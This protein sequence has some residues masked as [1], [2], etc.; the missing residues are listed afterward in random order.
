[1]EQKEPLLSGTRWEKEFEEP[2][3]AHWKDSGMFAFR[4]GRKPVFSIDTPPPYVNAPVHIGHAVTYTIMDMIA[5]YK[6]MRGFEV[7]FP[8][9]LDRNGLPIEVAAEKKF[10]VSMSA[11]PRE[12]FL[13]LCE[14][15]LE[16][17]S[18]ESIDVFYKLGHSY[19]SWIRDDKAGGMYYTDS[20]SYRALTQS[21]FI[22]LWNKG[23]IYPDEKVNNYCPHCRT[24][25]ADSE[26]DYRE[27]PTDFYHIK[28]RVKETAETVIIAT[29]RPELLMTCAMI[30][31]N[32]NDAKYAH[33]NGRT[34]VI[35]LFH[36]E[37]P[38][39]PHPYA[40]M[41]SG[42][43]LVMMCSFGD[44]TDIRFFRE[45][46]LKPVIAIKED[47]TMNE[48]AG[49][50]AGLPVKEARKRVV[51]ELE[52]HDLLDKVQKISHK[53]PICERSKTPVEFISLPEYYV[54]Q[55]DFKEEML[56][57][58]KKT[59]FF[60]PKSRQ[61]LLDWINALSMDWAISRKR[62]YATEIPLWYCKNCLQPIV[63]PKGKYY[64]PWKERPPV[65]KCPRCE[66]IE[67]TPE[68]RVFDT[69]FDSSISPLYILRY[70]ENPKF[71]HNS[72]PC[73][74][75]PQGKE[76]VRTWLY[77]SLLRAHQLTGNPIF[78]NI[79]IHYHVLDERG[80]KMSKSLGNVINP[81]EIVGRFGAEPFRIWCALE[82]NITE[83][84]IK[85]SLDRIEAGSKFLTKLWN[86]A[87]FIS[88]FPKPK[89]EGELQEIDKWI[90]KEL[91]KLIELTRNNYDEFNF[92]RPAQEIRHFIWETLA[93][94]YLELI[95]RRAYNH[96]GK[97]AKGQQE[98]AISTLYHVLEKVLLLLSPIG[99]FSTHKIYGDIWKA[100]IESQPFPK[101]DKKASSWRIPFTTED[102]MQLNGRIWKHKKDKGLSLKAPVKKLVV[103]RKFKP[104]AHEIISTHHVQ[105]LKYGSRFHMTLGDAEHKKK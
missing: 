50:L 103:R 57:I 60:A 43:G 20:P 95:K 5:R 30:I 10:N 51:E 15:M 69:W 64:R 46:G 99:C 84:D 89:A 104:I 37:V 97:F 27:A 94:H 77:Y 25:I 1:M 42:S 13:K 70:L 55:L 79:W 40:K 48:N 83:G 93:S 66:N 6:R 2:I 12:E 21:T 82:G 65:K 14:K 76:I 45:A 92:N 23:L 32:P 71:F 75:R 7:L 98:A 61:I 11:T 74:L 52:R 54:K 62:Y 87:R 91:N 18:S 44:Y 100:D 72:V 34:A 96:D 47:G 4:E 102:L 101:P 68:E 26:I 49:F 56:D 24:T 22:G 86:V 39:K 53:I 19:N 41:E 38:L 9:G 105:S 81:H 63:P 31:Y 28:F 16:E 59:K 90:L 80:I 67:F 78:D 33:L 36:K 8:L 29:T 73:S 17:S 58:A 88:M 85:C 3:R 35:P